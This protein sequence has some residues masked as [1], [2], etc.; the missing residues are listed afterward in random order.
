MRARKSW[1]EPDGFLEPRD[2]LAQR[3]FAA[4]PPQV[5]RL[6]VA[7]VGRHVARAHG[8]RPAVRTRELHLQRVRDLDSDFLLHLEDIGEIS[9]PRLRPE[10]TVGARVDQ[11]RGHA[12]AL[13]VAP[14]AAFEDVRHLKGR[15]HAAQIDLAPAERE[16]RSPR[17]HAQ[18]GDLRERVQDLLGQSIGKV[19]GIVRVTHIDERQHG[20]RL[21]G[22]RR[23]RRWSGGHRRRSGLGRRRDR[24]A[25]TV[26]TPENPAARQEQQG[27]NG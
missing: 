27:E 20:D 18:A 6:E 8:A 19:L 14:H 26:V 12:D 23:L 24:L 1:V 13:L 17:R 25:R 15:C 4:L 9:I 22:D 5:P 16:R 3:S 21:L 2:T 7:L 11:L 10:V